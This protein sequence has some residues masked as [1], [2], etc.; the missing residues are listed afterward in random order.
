M[1]SGLHFAN[2][3]D[4]FEAFA[5]AKEDIRARPDAES[6]LQFF[7]ALSKSRTPE[8]AVTFGA[9]LLP[10]RRAVWWGHECVRSVIHLLSD[11]DLK[12]LQLAES[13]VREPEEEHR[14]RA[15]DEGLNARTKTPGAWIA[16]AAGWSGGSLAPP[17]APKVPPP[18]YLTARA[19]NAGIL[20]ALAR[21]DIPHRAGTLQA[22]VEMGIGL[23]GR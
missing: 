6:S 23:A 11:Q 16:L 17:E 14:I 22:F 7:A 20:G 21:V 2:A 1:E 9:Y 12:M 13:W 15:M 8:E 18:T 3:K 10:R 4:L 19:V 5:T